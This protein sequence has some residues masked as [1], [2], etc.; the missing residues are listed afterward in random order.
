MSITAL[1]GAGNVTSAESSSADTLAGNK[2]ASIADG[3]ALWAAIYYRNSGGTL[4][5]PGGWTAGKT[6]TGNASVGLYVKPIATASGE[7]ATYSFGV[8][9]VGSSRCI[10]LIGRI[11]GADL[12]DL[13][14]AA[15]AVSL[16]TGTASLVHPSVTAA[17]GL[18]LSVSTCNRSNATPSVFSE[19]GAMTQVAQEAVVDGSS[20]SSVQVAQALVSSG[21]TGT[22]TAAMAPSAN[23]SAGFLVTL[24]PAPAAATL[25]AP[26][27]RRSQY[28]NLLIR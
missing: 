23:N 16:Y 6:D 9:G 7:P 15:G 11:T 25:A 1:T 28:R 17:G 24:N 18:L 21:A 5:A 3:D 13:V 27:A 26:P 22:R 10:L 12:S 19:D 4:T 20:S 14:D 2:P 8:T